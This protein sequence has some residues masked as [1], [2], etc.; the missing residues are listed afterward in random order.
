MAFNNCNKSFHSALAATLGTRIGK[1]ANPGR[2]TLKRAGGLDL[3]FGIQE[4]V[5]S[6]IFLFLSPFPFCIG[7]SDNN[8]L[9]AQAARAWPRSFS[10]A[11]EK[12]IRSQY[13]QP[14]AAYLQRIL[15]ATKLALQDAFS[16]YSL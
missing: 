6:S 2:T 14:N 1:E 3:C 9:S 4:A 8:I 7:L 15:L 16:L 10:V 5:F 12:L 13:V 11:G